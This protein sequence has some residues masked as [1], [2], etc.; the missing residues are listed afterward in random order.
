MQ[1]RGFRWYQTT[2][3][4]VETGARTISFDEAAAL[5]LALDFDLSALAAS[6]LNRALDT[7]QQLYL[8]VAE[9]EERLLALRGQLE[10]AEVN[11]QA[12]LNAQA[13][14]APTFRRPPDLTEEELTEMYQRDLAALRKR[15]KRKGAS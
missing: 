7:H 5:A 3:N 9:Q 8:E 11:L 12:E 14:H 4:R 10:Q 1:A 6:D 15:S 13:A 2:V